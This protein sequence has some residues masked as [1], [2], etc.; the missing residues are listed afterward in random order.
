MAID[1]YLENHAAKLS[2]QEKLLT[3]S[4]QGI[5]SEVLFHI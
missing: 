1:A 5:D 4:N 2:S 3:L